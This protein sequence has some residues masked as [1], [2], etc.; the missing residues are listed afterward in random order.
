MTL[1]WRRDGRGNDTDGLTIR[2]NERVT[3]KGVVKS[4]ISSFHLRQSG[5][6]P[7]SRFVLALL[8][9]I[10][11]QMSRCCPWGAGSFPHTP[12]DLPDGAGIQ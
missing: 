8:A 1:K 2:P 11:W 4:A 3:T 12:C 5:S 7:K 6:R 9:M 10:C